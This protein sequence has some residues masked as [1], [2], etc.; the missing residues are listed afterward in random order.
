M[1]FDRLLSWVRLWIIVLLVGFALL[2]TGLR[3]AANLVS[4]YRDQLQ[5]TLSEAVGIHLEFQTITARMSQLDPEVKV[6][7]LLLFDESPEQADALVRS[8]S[9]RVDLFRSILEQRL[10]VRSLNISGLELILKQM[11]SGHWTFANRLLEPAERSLLDFARIEE[12]ALTNFAIRLEQTKQDWLVTAVNPSGLFLGRQEGHRVAKGTLNLMLDQGYAGQS[13]ELQNLRFSASFDDEPGR[14]LSSDFTAYVELNGLPSSLFEARFPLITGLE[15]LRASTWMKSESG[16]GSF[17]GEIIVDSARPQT[18]ASN[19]S[20]DSVAALSAKVAIDG[21][22]DL[23]VAELDLTAR[24]EKLM[25]GDRHFKPEPIVVALN[26]RSALPLAA[27][28]LSNIKLTQETLDGLIE[29]GAMS[30]SQAEKLLMFRPIFDI[31][32]V[33]ITASVDSPAETLRVQADVDYAS[34]STDGSLPAFSGLTGFLDV[35]LR[36]GTVGIN[37]RDFAL[38]FPLLYP[39]PWRLDEVRGQLAY[40]SEEGKWQISSGLLEAD[41]HSLEAKGKLLINMTPDFA[42]RNWGLVIGAHDFVARDSLPFIPGTVPAA[43]TNWLEKAVVSGGAGETGILVHGS[44]DRR[45]PKKEKIYSVSTEAKGLE[46]NFD[47]RWPNLIEV[48]GPVLVDNRGVAAKD[49]NGQLFGARLAGGAVSTF[50]PSWVEVADQ[51][52]VDVNFEGVVRDLVDALNTKPVADAVN[53]FAD[54]WDGAGSVSGKL[55]LEVPLDASGKSISV[56][57]KGTIQ[58]ATLEMGNFDL[59]LTDLTSDFHYSSDNGLTAPRAQFRMLGEPITA[60]ISSEAAGAGVVTSV[61]IE[62]IVNLAA[63]QGWLNLSVLNFV[64][65]S[66]DF[67]AMIQVPYGGR[68]NQPSI[69]VSSMLE[70]VTISM[71]PPL[72]KIRANSKQDFR[73]MQLFDESGSELS[74]EVRNGFSGILRLEDEQVIGGLVRLGDTQPQVGAFDALRVEGETDYVGAEEWIEFI[75]AFEAVSAEDAA[76]FRDRLDYV[77]INVGTLDFFGLEFSDASLSVTADVDYWVFDVIDD[78]LKGQIR[79]SDDPSTPV[80]ALIDYLALTSEDDGDPLQG[81][82]SEDLVPIHVDVRSLILDEEDYGQWMFDVSP[83]ESTVL[84]EN[85]VANVKGMVIAGSAPLYWDPSSELPFTKFE[86]SIDIA[87]VKSSLEAWGFAAG[88][89]GADFS[90]NGSFE[91]PGSPLNIEENDLTG[92]LA[93]TGG[94]G[95]IVQADASSGAL[96]LLGIFDFAEIAQ[97][98]SLDLANVLGDGHAFNAMQ[99]SF[100]MTPGLIKTN[101]PIVMSGP[102]SQ[103]TFAGD[104]SLPSEAIDY[105]LVVTLPLN[106]NLPWYAAYSA[107]ATG[108]LVGAGVLIAQQVFRDQIDELTSLKYEI[109]GSLEDPSVELVSVFDASLRDTNEAV[110]EPAPAETTGGSNE[111]QGDD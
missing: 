103:L 83:G 66:A 25:L 80:E 108:P 56:Q 75:E 18:V 88:L 84:I 101:E 61:D 5:R 53:D 100:S 47:E 109:N 111:G 92:S 58:G 70:G 87:D 30:P 37:A 50:N 11:Q 20:N 110:P 81:V 19:P 73:L 8:M 97:R 99:G 82:Q 104:L 69:E 57:T 43:V 21:G 40:R 3:F 107:I 48:A 4:G 96:K 31:D 95:R 91:W 34:I 46:L 24:A 94:K 90:F 71:P 44:L 79:L 45:Q 38:H 6:Q 76:A 55:A 35:G 12:L 85:L 102:G 27:G 68:V 39:E 16:S 2:I 105:D 59:V 1:T 62:G 22:F 28:K 67:Q 29:A 63:L 26:W 14:F 10:V 106:K 52:Q 86:G 77:A 51:I 78:E 17:K 49:L 93:F 7:E 60:V 15:G 65:G 41:V 74:F 64:E 32:D 13:F 42:S 33:M 89:E 23:N 36:G 9:V 54:D 72:S 98:L